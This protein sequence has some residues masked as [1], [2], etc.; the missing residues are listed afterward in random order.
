MVNDMD[1][2]RHYKKVTIILRRI[3]VVATLLLYNVFP[4]KNIFLVRINS[5]RAPIREW[6]H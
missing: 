6:M 3:M 2:L 5:V 1:K 4:M